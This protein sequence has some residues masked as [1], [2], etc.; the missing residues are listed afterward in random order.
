M[1]IISDHRQKN[2]DW[3]P[4]IARIH[5]YIFLWNS[6]AENII[7]N[8]I[9]T[10]LNLIPYLSYE[11]PIMHEISLI[12][13]HLSGKSFHLSFTPVQLQLILFKIQVALFSP[14]LITSRSSSYQPWNRS[15]WLDHKSPSNGLNPDYHY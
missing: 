13:C 4:F 8:L 11:I 7:S 1:D 9:V 10:H 5:T 2:V 3:F 6:E 15:L 14:L 12:S